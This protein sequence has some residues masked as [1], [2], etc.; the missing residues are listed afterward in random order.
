VTAPG[1][2]GG[3]VLEW[4]RRARGAWA[5]RDAVEVPLVEEA[6]RYEVGAGSPEAPIA[7]W[8]TAAP[9][10]TLAAGDLAPL[11]PGTL[12]WVRQIGIHARS[13]ALPLLILA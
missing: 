3:L 10:L 8:P 11:P 13:P 7:L 12:L 4:T 1:P 2:D 6:E 9:A 5:W